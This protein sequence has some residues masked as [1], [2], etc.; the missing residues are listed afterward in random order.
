MISAGFIY[1]HRV[2][3]TQDIP[4]MKLSADCPVSPEFR[5]EID[6]WMIEFFGV[7]NI[8]PDGSIMKDANSLHMNPRTW[9]ELKKGG[10]A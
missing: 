10:A 4:K 7:I 2:F 3:L 1:G 8:L 9:A 6:A 5:V